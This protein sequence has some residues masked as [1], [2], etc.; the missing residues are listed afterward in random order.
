MAVYGTAQHDRKGE[1]LAKL[2]RACSS[3]ANYPFMV[4]GDFNIIRNS[5]EKN[6]NRYNDTWPRLFNVVIETLNLR[7]IKMSSRKFTWAN[8][9]EVPTYEKL[10]RVLVSTE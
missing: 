7:E 9:A 3:C 5:S 6:N 4:G 10:D 1:F 8:Y 2:V